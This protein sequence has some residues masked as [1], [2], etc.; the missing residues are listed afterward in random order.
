MAERRCFSRKVVESDAFRKLSDSCQTLYLHL[1][2]A[3]DDDGFIN[4]AGGIASMSENG[5][6]N[7]EM[8]VRAKFL[9]QFGDI[10]VVKHWRISNSLKSDRI[11]EPAYPAIAAAIYVNSNRAYTLRREC[12]GKSLLEIKTGRRP[13]AGMES[14]P[15]RTE[16]KRTEENRREENPAFAELR[17]RYPPARLGDAQRAWEAY[18]SQVLTEADGKQVLE[19]LEYWIN[20][21]QWKKNGG[22]FIPYLANWLARGC[23]KERPAGDGPSGILGGAELAAIR[24]ILEEQE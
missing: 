8:L 5:A 15:N 7:L 11:K 14:K 1:N 13:R 22:Q 16:E 18:T 23:W 3:A 17:M 19:N 24:Q 9:I 12:G 2:M 10:Y 21:D 6:E 4:C 20:S